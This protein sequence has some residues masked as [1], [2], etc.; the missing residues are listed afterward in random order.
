MCRL[1]DDSGLG[2]ALNKQEPVFGPEI[3]EELRDLER[4]LQRVDAHRQP[5]D[6]LRDPFVEKAGEQAATLLASIESR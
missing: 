5:E 3:D 2:D 6:L 4:L 1:F